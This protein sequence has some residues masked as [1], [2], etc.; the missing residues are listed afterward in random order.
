VVTHPNNVAN[1][2]ELAIG[3]KSALPKALVHVFLWKFDL[4]RNPS[5]A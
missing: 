5:Y 3:F 4:V 1:D 2:V